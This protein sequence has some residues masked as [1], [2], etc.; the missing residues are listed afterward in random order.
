MSSVKESNELTNHHPAFYFL[1]YL[2]SHA[3][4]QKP[5]KVGNNSVEEIFVI[6]C[7]SAEDMSNPE[8]CQMN[9]FDTR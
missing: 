5:D 7:F 8:L 1:T 3:K 6:L 9:T 4:V 2:V